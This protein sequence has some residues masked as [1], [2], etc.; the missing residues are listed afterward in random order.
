MLKINLSKCE[1][2]I[3]NKTNYIEIIFINLHLN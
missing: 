3:N 1:I 2:N